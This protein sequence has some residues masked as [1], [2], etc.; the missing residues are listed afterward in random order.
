MKFYLK[1][2][3]L[4]EVL[5]AI[6]ILLIGTVGATSILSSAIRSAQ[7]ARLN[8]IA[9]QLAQEGVELVR[10][11]RDESFIA[12]QDIGSG[13]AGGPPGPNACPDQV[14]GSWPKGIDWISVTQGNPFINI[15]NPP[16]GDIP[17]YF[18][19]TYGYNHQGIGSA[20]PFRRRIYIRT[21]QASD[22]S[23]LALKVNVEMKWSDRGTNKTF[24]VEDHLY[25]W[26]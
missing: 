22:G 15:G 13:I 25:N 10:R 3:S 20:S 11:V 18:D 5:V 4:V 26:R 8:L 7:S 9:A 1:A 17:L 12:T 21:T 2:F 23:T 16:S 24:C 14:I 6:S 19:S